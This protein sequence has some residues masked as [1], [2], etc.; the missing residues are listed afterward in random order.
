MSE[1]FGDR[2]THNDDIE[3]AYEALRE[4]ERETP[5]LRAEVARLT[6]KLPVAK[7]DARTWKLRVD[8]SANMIDGLEAALAAANEREAKLL[9]QL[10]SF[11][12]E[13]GYIDYKKCRHIHTKP[14][15]PGWVICQ[16]CGYTIKTPPP[17]QE[18]PHTN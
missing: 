12:D 17:A 7:Q 4:Y 11:R 3:D 18:A 8:E 6:A 15:L 16:D 5:K 14:E 9:E 1:D 13:D 10:N 2:I